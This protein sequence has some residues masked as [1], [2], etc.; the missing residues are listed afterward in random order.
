ML[1]GVEFWNVSVSFVRKNFALGR[2]MLTSQRDDE[3][4]CEVYVDDDV[5]NNERKHGNLFHAN[6]AYP[7]IVDIRD[8]PAAALVEFPMLLA[9]THQTKF[10][11][12]TT[13]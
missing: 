2:V 10:M 9:F 7:V 13:R 6:N 4:D 1:I 11:T 3:E 8:T 5:E 12:M